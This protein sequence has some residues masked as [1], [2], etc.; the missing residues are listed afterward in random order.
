MV[1]NLSAFCTFVQFS[2]VWFL[3]VSFGFCLFPLGDWEGLRFVI[4][5]LLG[6]FTYLFMY[7]TVK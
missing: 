3:S 4:V 1:A 5:A 2:L 7:I 6:L